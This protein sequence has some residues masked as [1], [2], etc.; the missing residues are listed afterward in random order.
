M[1]GLRI[2]ILNMSVVLLMRHM[3]LVTLV[4]VCRRCGMW[5]GLRRNVLVLFLGVGNVIGVIVMS[6]NRLW[7]IIILNMVGGLVALRGRRDT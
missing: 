2:R 6:R 1:I 3:N 7:R 4:R 5:I